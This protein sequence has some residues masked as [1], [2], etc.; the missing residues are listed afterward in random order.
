MDV[1]PTVVSVEGGVE[2]QMAQ[3]TNSVLGDTA[4]QPMHEDLSWGVLRGQLV[5]M[6]QRLAQRWMAV[7]LVNTPAARPPAVAKFD[8][9]QEPRHVCSIGT[10]TSKG[11]ADGHLS[12]RNTSSSRDSAQVSSPSRI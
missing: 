2:R 6:R 1:S 4:I 12:R 8:R 5:E 10:G 7:E 3:E 11:R 9:P